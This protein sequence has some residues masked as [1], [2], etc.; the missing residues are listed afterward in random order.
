MVLA[1]FTYY[2]GPI[3]VGPDAASAAAGVPVLLADEDTLALGS[4]EDR[5][6]RV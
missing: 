5:H 4:G 3:A 2:V 6:C 1:L